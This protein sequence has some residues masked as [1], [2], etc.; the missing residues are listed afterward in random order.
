MEG[1][2]SVWSNAFWDASCT[3]RQQTLPYRP[4]R[5]SSSSFKPGRVRGIVNVFERSTS[6]SSDVGDDSSPHKRLGTPEKPPTAPITRRGGKRRQNTFWDMSET[7][8]D[9][10]AD[11]KGANLKS[12][13]TANQSRSPANAPFI[14]RSSAIT[15]HHIPLVDQDDAEAT[16][17]PAIG[18]RNNDH[19]LVPVLPPPSGTPLDAVLLEVLEDAPSQ[20][21]QSGEPDS[22]FPV[23]REPD[24]DVQEDDSSSSTPHNT[25]RE[26]EIVSLSLPRE[27][28]EEELSMA[29]LYAEM[30]GEP[31]P[32]PRVIPVESSAEI[33]RFRPVRESPT[34][35]PTALRPVKGKSSS[36][37]KDRKK[38]DATAP[39][40][41]QIPAGLHSLFVQQHDH[42]A[43]PSPD[44]YVVSS[45]GPAP[46]ER[47]EAALRAVD[48]LK[49]RLEVV[50]AKLAA[51]ENAEAERERKAQVRH[52]RKTGP[53]GRCS[54]V[55][56]ER[57]GTGADEFDMSTRSATS[58][59][60]QIMR[61][62]VFGDGDGD[63]NRY[64]GTRMRTWQSASILL[65]GATTGVSV[66]LI[67]LL[68]RQ[69]VWNR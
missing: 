28:E 23:F 55:N 2:D 56:V 22:S 47:E 59:S 27:E 31:A 20:T 37:V 40:G 64:R 24:V 52:V 36:S 12:T 13:S 53:Q 17:S 16:S 58:R 68:L 15:E 48:V 34:R 57:L 11:R 30:Y 42:D 5:V 49:T 67:P 8:N 46:T 66:M 19:D 63:G 4:S 1:V 10:D 60:V 35:P 29:E 39:Q 61:D 45:P 44:I 50:E 41:S 21:H 54:L 18:H 32:E 6:E 69:F 3:L 33:M 25:T 26:I 65:A 62:I 14:S 38:E 7:E 51:M 9:S 43:E